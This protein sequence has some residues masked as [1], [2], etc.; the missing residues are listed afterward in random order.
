MSVGGSVP[1]EPTPSLADAFRKSVN[2]TGPV[3]I[4]LDGDGDMLAPVDVTYTLRADLTQFAAFDGTRHEPGA[5]RRHHRHPSVADR[6]GGCAV[7]H[8]DRHHPG[9]GRRHLPGGGRLLR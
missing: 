4:G 9:G 6:V 2:P 8:G 1:A 5:E 3:V 7:H